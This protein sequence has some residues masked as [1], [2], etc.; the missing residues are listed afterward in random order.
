MIA[1]E[2][3]FQG[4]ALFL[5]HT[6]TA[7]STIKEK[8][9]LGHTK[10][11]RVANWQDSGDRSQPDPLAGLGD[12]KSTRAATGRIQGTVVSLIRNPGRSR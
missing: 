1:E 9:S 5:S 7:I 3:K 6:K 8:F 11:I 12:T 4:K 10:S 2:E